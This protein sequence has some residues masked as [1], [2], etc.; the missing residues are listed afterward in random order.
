MQHQTCSISALQT[1][2]YHSTR[3]NEEAA[4][5]PVD[6]APEVVKDEGFLGTGLSMVWIRMPRLFLLLQFHFI[7]ISSSSRR[8]NY[9]G[10]SSSS[11]YPKQLGSKELQIY[12]LNLI[13]QEILDLILQRWK[14]RLNQRINY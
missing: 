13:S 2:H 12:Y 3:E 1:L 14:V 10:C 9:L 5:A 8:K 11:A 7:A 6:K 4:A